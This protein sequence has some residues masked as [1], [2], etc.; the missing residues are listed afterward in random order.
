MFANRLFFASILALS[1]LGLTGCI[2]GTSPAS[3]FYLLEPIEI[4]AVIPSAETAPRLIALAP[5]HIPY[6]LDRAQIVTATDQNAYKVA[7]YQRWA[8]RLDEN[9]GRVM[10]QD[11]TRLV[12]AEVV[13]ATGTARAKQAEYR[14]T[15]NILQFH[16]NP[17]AQAVLVAQWTLAKGGDVLVSRVANYHETSS[18]T[19]YRLMVKALNL[20]LNRLSREIAEAIKLI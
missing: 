13:Q 7:E 1:T 14:V 6:Y 20:N 5:V 9:I 12:P 18:S 11:L 17:Q 15:V 4:A 8:E 3:Q 19:D 2:G 10:T 16:I